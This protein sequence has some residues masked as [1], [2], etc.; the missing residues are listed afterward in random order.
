MAYRA[1][2]LGR[3]READDVISAAVAGA[4]EIATAEHSRWV[5]MRRAVVVLN[6]WCHDTAERAAR[7]QLVADEARERRAAEAAIC[8]LLPPEAVRGTAAY[9]EARARAH[10]EA[11]H[12]VEW[13]SITRGVMPGLLG[14]MARLELDA[15]LLCVECEAAD[16]LALLRTCRAAFYPYA[17]ALLADADEPR[18][19]AALEAERAMYVSHLKR[20]STAMGVFFLIGPGPG[21]EFD[22]RVV[23]TTEWEDGALSLFNAFVAS[24]TRIGA[25][26]IIIAEGAAR[27]AYGGVAATE[28][29]ERALL[30][31]A[32]WRLRLVLLQG[33]SGWSPHAATHSEEGARRMVAVD[34]YRHRRRIL[35]DA[36]ALY[37]HSAIPTEER[38]A[39]SRL[40]HEEAAAYSTQ[41]LAAAATVL[42]G[43]V[44]PSIRSGISAQHAAWVAARVDTAHAHRVLAAES[45]ARAT[46]EGERVLMVNFLAGAEYLMF[47]ELRRRNFIIADVAA[48]AARTASIEEARAGSRLHYAVYQSPLYEV[49]EHDFV[50]FH[51]SGTTGPA[52]A[53]MPLAF[54][55]SSA[56]RNIMQS[57]QQQQPLHGQHLVPIHLRND[58]LSHQDAHAAD[59]LHHSPLTRSSTVGR[60]FANR[61]YAV[62]SPY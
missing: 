19:R 36:A 34:E 24:R 39:R 48:R 53:T 13:R 33:E 58:Q 54:A 40:V 7:A 16:R 25:M 2:L 50:P 23:V 61:A 6:L 26:E 38:A 15:R 14:D 12:A 1:V 60:L 31:S 8:D 18:R 55:S 62:E 45:A 51:S 59:S 11:L 10:I 20:H 52:S 37:G 47:L 17:L 4:R 3:A 9:D 46:I 42:I 32:M 57:H 44:E 29:R 30:T 22:G 43:L 35:A 28:A 5:E 21:S 49:A 41:L 56:Q 27:R